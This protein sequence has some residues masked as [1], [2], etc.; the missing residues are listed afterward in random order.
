ME[1]T[2]KLQGKSEKEIRDLKRQQ[3][4]EIITSTELLLEQQNHRK[5]TS[6]SSRT[7]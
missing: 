4:D 5:S 3:T 2:L 6:R 7:E 1:N